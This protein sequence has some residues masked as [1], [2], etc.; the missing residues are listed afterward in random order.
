MDDTVEVTFWVKESLEY[1]VGM[2]SKIGT[3]TSRGMRT[4]PGL[5]FTQPAPKAPIERT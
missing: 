4:V 2:K 3:P 5:T 1:D